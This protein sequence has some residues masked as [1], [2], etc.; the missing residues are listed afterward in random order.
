MCVVH[1]DRRV[2]TDRRFPKQCIIGIVSTMRTKQSIAYEMISHGSWSSPIERQRKK[3]R[4]IRQMCLKKR[5]E[6]FRMTTVDIVLITGRQLVR[7]KKY[8][9]LQHTCSNNAHVRVHGKERKWFTV[10][11]K[12]H[13]GCSLSQSVSKNIFP[14]LLKMKILKKQNY[15]LPYKQNTKHRTGAEKKKSLNT[16]RKGKTKQNTPSIRN[17]WVVFNENNKRQHL[18]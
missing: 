3:K 17:N 14:C 5:K 4:S 8:M 9:P 1:A 11:I 7:L 15:S 12:P 6:T 10:L 2:V 13:L 16:K 18:W